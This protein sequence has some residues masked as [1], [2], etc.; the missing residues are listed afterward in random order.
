MLSHPQCLLCHFCGGDRFFSSHIQMTI[1]VILI[2]KKCDYNF[3]RKVMQNKLRTKTT[4]SFF[5]FLCR[6]WVFLYSNSMTI[7][8]TYF[9]LTK[10]DY[11]FLMKIMLKRWWNS[12]QNP[13]YFYSFL[14]S[15]DWLSNSDLTKRWK[16]D[17]NFH[18]KMK[19]T[20]CIQNKFILSTNRASSNCQ[21][22]V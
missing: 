1:F 7:F 16:F 3:H 4:L 15:D 17:Y 8:R 10:C 21:D 6:K 2:L 22:Y 5:L 12:K 14:K 13:P 20:N 9:D 19:Q 11:N 18:L